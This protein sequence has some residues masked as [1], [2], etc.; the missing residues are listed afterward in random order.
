VD[1]VAKNCQVLVVFVSV[2]ACLLFLLEEVFATSISH[3]S[4]CLLPSLLPSRTVKK[5]TQKHRMEF[6]IK[7]GVAGD[8]GK[9][10]GKAGA[11]EGKGVTLAL[12]F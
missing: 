9:W 5:K 3:G 6:R 4:P 11:L 10:N 7:F 12:Y 1:S 2:R 8:R